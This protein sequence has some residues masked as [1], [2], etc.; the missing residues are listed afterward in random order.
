MLNFDNTNGELTLESINNGKKLT[1][2][3]IED[4][5]NITGSELEY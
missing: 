3:E 1:D 2:Q 5:F 4:S